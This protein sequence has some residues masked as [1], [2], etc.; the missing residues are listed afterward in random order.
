MNHQVKLTVVMTHPVQYFAPWFRYIAAHCPDIKLTVLYAIQPT[1][2]QQGVGFGQSFS[3]DANLTD[4]YHCRFVRPARATDTVS[5][6]SFW[7]L[8]VPVIG[9][10]IE[11]TRP[12]VVLTN[13]WHSI[14]LLRALWAC[15][16]RRIPV[17]YR[18][19]TH[20]GAA[21]C[22]WRGTLWAARTQ[23]LLKVF[24]AYLSVG[25]RV[26]EYLLRQGILESR[27][28]SA[29]HCVDNEFFA[30]TAALYQTERTRSAARNAFGCTDTDFVVL[31]VG[32]LEPVKRPLDAIQAVAQLGS[33]ARLLVVGTGELACQAR[34]EAERLGL[35]VTWAGFLN[36]SEL[37]RAYAVADCLVL[38]S[39]Q[40]TWGLVVNEALATGLP[41]VV[42]DRVGC[43][44]DLITDGETGAMFP[45]G[46]IS[47]LTS[48]L[49][50]IRERRRAGHDFAPAC[51]D[52]I[53]RYSFAT[54]T[55][56]LRA[57]CQSV[58]SPDRLPVMLAN[59][60]RSP[61]IIACC[62]GMVIVS[63][64]ERMT[65][66]VLRSARE[67]GAAVHCIV[68]TW[69]NHRIVKLAEQIQA[70]WSTGYYWYGFGRQL[71]NPLKGAQF[72]WDIMRTSMGLLKDVYHFRP[73]HVLLPDFVAVL[74]NAPALVLLRLL[75]V[76]SIFR[77]GNIP[78]EGRFS[79]WM[80]RIV[81]PSIVSRFVAIS[82]FGANRLRMTGVSPQKITT[83]RNSPVH[84]TVASDAD[85]DVIALVHT[86]K[87]LLCVG[88][89]APFKG[90]H[91][92]IDA[93]VALLDLGYDIQAVI[94]GRIP[95]WPPEFVSYTKKLQRT[96][97]TAGVQ[98]RVHF[99]GERDN[100]LEIMRASYLLGAPI[101][102]EETFGNVVLEAKSVG[103]PVVAFARGALPELVEH[104]VTG[105]LCQDMT[106]ESLITGFRCF[107]DDSQRRKRASVASVASFA[108]PTCDMIPAQ[109]RERWWALWTET[110]PQLREMRDRRP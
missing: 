31:F 81:L 46:D 44:P 11:E 61:R 95:E 5:S 12:D 50:R 86:R 36:Q 19:D 102:Q 93:V 14:T 4:G 85:A 87:T 91:I 42:S 73:T 32:K 76:P 82:H 69:E 71:C 57:A 53:A 40:E 106:V 43:A 103:L 70:S 110:S 54:A 55:S 38:P 65:F 48:A 6:E 34:S 18:G 79:T 23:M 41:C 96:V 52:R 92:F 64:L 30:N 66:E 84:R 29:P 1:L 16:R 9:T 72:L 8:D 51:R 59:T 90:T 80:W 10:A 94:I 67:Q 37:G 47:A 3:W 88:Q 39:T 100:I 17:L 68:N 45:M 27:I 56:G 60:H 62:G 107:L 105:V 24:S 20:L 26:Y 13:G 74:R 7:G 49:E 22:G 15:R 21:P 35:Q 25:H 75:G 33:H 97:A 108:H 58:V 101:V 109:F 28:F 89:I 78:E 63:G 99:V 104:Q 98:D 83:I 2:E 77:V